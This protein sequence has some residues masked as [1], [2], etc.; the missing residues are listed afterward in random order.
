MGEKSW[1]N[2]DD[3]AMVEAVLG[4]EPFEFLVSLAS[5]N[6]LSEFVSSARDLSV[7]QGLCK[8]VEGS[9]WTYAIFWQVSGSKS[10]RSALIW[11]DGHCREP[12][13]SEVEDRNCSGDQKLEE[14]DL[15]KRV[16]LKLHACFGRSEEDNY[17]ANLD[18]VSDVDMF[19]LT[20]MYHSFPFDKP[21]SP[22]QSFNSGRSIWVSDTKSCLEHYQSRSYLAKSAQFRTLVFVPVKSGVVEIGSV[23]SVPEEQNMI[24]MVKTIFGGSDSVRH[25]LSV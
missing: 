15:K 8:I 20:S 21:S 24:Q 10:G 19:Y 25:V 17:A 14:G 2:E 9:D 4:T 23:K 18:L 12:K 16:L 6:V 7:Q 5:G 13:G 22:A 11:G 3:K 1:L